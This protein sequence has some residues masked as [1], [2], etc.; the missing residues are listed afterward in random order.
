M[1]PY[2]GLA[3][4]IWSG[5]NSQFREIVFQISKYPGPILKFPKF[6]FFAR[7]VGREI[8]KD[9]DRLAEEWTTVNAP[10]RTPKNVCIQLEFSECVLYMLRALVHIFIF[11]LWHIVPPFPLFSLSLFRI[12]SLFQRVMSSIQLQNW[13]RYS[14]ERASQSLKGIWNFGG[15]NSRSNSKY[16]EFEMRAQ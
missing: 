13:R 12:R 8:W 9:Q 4:Q 7:R 16:L 1:L 10:A 11:R 6:L 15:E 5:S 14:R 2:A 3:F